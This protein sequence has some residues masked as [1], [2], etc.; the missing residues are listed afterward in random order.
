[1]RIAFTVIYLLTMVVAVALIKIYEP[2]TD[3]GT[4]LFVGLG[5]AW[6]LSLPWSL[7]TLLVI[8][9]FMHD[10]SSPIFLGFFVFAGILNAILFNIR[11]IKDWFASRGDERWIKSE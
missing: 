5:V 9:W 7:L 1:M 3:N 11:A 8:W 4:L 2:P 10:Y 6:I